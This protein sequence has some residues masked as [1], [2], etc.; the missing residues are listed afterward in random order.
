[1]AQLL[2]SVSHSITLC[3][4]TMRSHFQFPKFAMLSP[5]G[6][7]SLFSEQQSCTQPPLPG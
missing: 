2:P 4:L 5:L 6:L 3:A 7:C 1:M